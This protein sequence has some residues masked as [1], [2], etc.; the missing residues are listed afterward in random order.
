MV[1]YPGR[2]ISIRRTALLSGDIVCIVGSI[3]LSAILRLGPEQAM[4]FC[5]I[6][7]WFA[8]SGSILIFILVFYA[9]GMYERQSL[10]RKDGSYFLPLVSVAI[11]LV[12][13]IVIFYWRQGGIGRGVLSLAGAF[14]FLTSWSMRHAYRMAVGRGL[15]SKKALIVGDGHE[16]E[17]VV[18][19]V[20]RTA[21]PG[22]KLVGCATVRRLGAGSFIGGIPVV[23][24]FDRLRECVDAFEI[25]TIIVATSLAREPAL[26][27]LLRPLRW[28]GVEVMDYAALHEVLAQEIPIDHIN[29][30]WLMN[31]AMNS[32]V[33]HIRQIKRIMD[34]AAA[35]TGLVLCAPLAL[36]AAIAIKLDS[37]GPVLFRQKRSGREGR[38]YTLLKFRTMRQDAEAVSG[39]VW[40]GKSDCRVTRVGRWFRKWRIDEIPQLI[41]V[42][43]GEMSLV[44]PRPE[45]PE[46]I[47]TL[48]NAI[49]FYKERLLVPPGITG[50]AQVKYPYA[51]SIEAAR[52]KLQYDLYYVKHMS[53]FLDILILL[54]TFKTIIVGL[55]H[56]EEEEE[57]DE[58]RGG[59]R[60]IPAPGGAAGAN[61]R[62]RSA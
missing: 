36:V 15:L 60:I 44:G 28:Q 40:A 18:R 5:L 41:N 59:G 2:R 25:E 34:L 20:T 11:A 9:S 52:R 24:T 35:I 56:S 4:R 51:A 31:A 62:A 50:W 3:A 37:P 23:G 14:I 21:D 48:D 12:I 29:D 22:I 26:L 46:F 55:A 45:R 8:L 54:R 39:A 43:R 16:L 38:H 58:T 6:D 57:P 1:F 49:P 33:I 19:L 7:H 27:R 47:E 42:L 10:T 30:E 13:T 17:D 61:G 53:T 32:S